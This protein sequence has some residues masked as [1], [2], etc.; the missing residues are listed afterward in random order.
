MSHLAS[1]DELDNPAAIEFTQRQIEEFDALRQQITE[2]TQG[3][4]QGSLAASSGILELPSDASSVRAPGF[5]AL[6][7][8]TLR[9]S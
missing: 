1:A 4:V 6:W 9:Q 8:V 7:R 5:H 3:P 2:S